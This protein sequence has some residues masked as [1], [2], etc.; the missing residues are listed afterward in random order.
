MSDSPLRKA[1][2]LSRGLA[3]AIGRRRTA[4]RV[5]YAPPGEPPWTPRRLPSEV[6]TE[7]Q[8]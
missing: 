7:L 1:A 3:D 5:G 2:E 6:I 8:H 4:V